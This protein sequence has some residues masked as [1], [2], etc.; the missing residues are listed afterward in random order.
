M[1][2]NFQVYVLYHEFPSMLSLVTR[3][4]PKKHY[5]ILLQASTFLG[6]PISLDGL[7]D[8]LDS[9]LVKNVVL[10]SEA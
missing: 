8:A 3:Y 7:E 6:C 1:V 10:G 9:P 2:V 4:C 5:E